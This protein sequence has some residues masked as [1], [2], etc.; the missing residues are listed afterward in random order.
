MNSTDEVGFVP[1]N[2]VHSTPL[3][4]RQFRFPFQ[5]TRSSGN[6]NVSG[7]GLLQL[8]TGQTDLEGNTTVNR[9][10]NV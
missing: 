1:S 10:L 6:N 2:A 9:R 5:P 8:D 3:L 4:I 7:K